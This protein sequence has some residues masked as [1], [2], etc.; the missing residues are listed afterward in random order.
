[1]SA[2]LELNAEIRTAVGRSASRRMRRVKEK[3]Q[4]LFMVLLKKDRI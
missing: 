1:M 4:R 3:F 2:A